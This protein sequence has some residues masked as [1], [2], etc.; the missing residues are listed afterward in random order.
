MCAHDKKV[1]FYMPNRKHMA[2]YWAH[3]K[4][5]DSGSVPYYIVTGLHTG[6]YNDMSSKIWST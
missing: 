1:V 6:S 3:G 4:E 5:P 2:N